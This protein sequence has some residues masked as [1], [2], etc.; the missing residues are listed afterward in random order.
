MNTCLEWATKE[1]HTRPRDIGMFAR[2]SGQT[3]EARQWQGEPMSSVRTNPQRPYYQWRSYD[4]PIPMGNS[5]FLSAIWSFLPDHSSP[6]QYQR[7]QPLYLVR[8]SSTKSAQI[9]HVSDQVISKSKRFSHKKDP[10]QN[11]SINTN[12]LSW[13]ISDKIFLGN[14]PTSHFHIAH[15]SMP[16]FWW[17]PQKVLQEITVRNWM[18]VNHPQEVCFIVFH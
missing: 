7:Q 3:R 14:G 2:H 16:T 11:R 9:P 12:Y 17:M 18:M 5:P 13:I 10:T 1:S 15:R 6:L 8:I 4:P